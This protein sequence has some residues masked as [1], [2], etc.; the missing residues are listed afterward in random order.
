MPVIRGRPKETKIADDQRNDLLR[1]LFDERKG[2]STTGGPSIF[3]IPLDQSDMLDVMV[4][5]NDW[6]GVRSED[7]TE[8]IKE[9]YRDHQEELA[10]ALGVTYEEAI[11]QGVL[12]Y[13]VRQRFGPQPKFDNEQVRSAYLSVGG[14]ERPDGEISLRYPTMSTAQTAVAKLQQLL[15]GTEWL[16]SHAD[17]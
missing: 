13:R 10:L 6:H 7:R 3:E 8:L 11:E 16:I 15:P 5:W 2:Q 4:V 1:R 9:A 12:P 14:V 17:P